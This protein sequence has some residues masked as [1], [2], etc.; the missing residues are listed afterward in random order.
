M[1]HTMGLVTLRRRP[2]SPFGTSLQSGRAH[3]LSNLVT[4]DIYTFSNKLRVNP[5]AAIDPFASLMDGLDLLQEFTITLH[6]RGFGTLQP[7]VISACCNTQK[8]AHQTNWIVIAT[9]LNAGVSHFDCLAKY[10][11]AS[12]KKS[13][14]FLICASSR[15]NAS[16]S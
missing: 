3:Q 9:T 11:A 7:S 10:A 12:F 4:S 16:S 15:F 8:A 2:V 14:S 5:R 13:R 1:R 6:A